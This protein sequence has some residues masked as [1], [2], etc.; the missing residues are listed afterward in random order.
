MTLSGTYRRLLNQCPLLHFQK[1]SEEVKLKDVNP[2]QILQMI[3]GLLRQRRV[4]GGGNA[5]SE[6]PST[7]RIEISFKSILNNR[8][9]PSKQEK[10]PPT[11]SDPGS[12]QQQQHA[13]SK[14]QNVDSLTVS[15]DQRQSLKSNTLYPKIPEPENRRN[16]S[17][18]KKTIDEDKLSKKEQKYN[19]IKKSS[20]DSLG[21]H[22]SKS[23][24]GARERRLLQYQR[25]RSY[26][27]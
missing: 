22:S 2:N 11:N 25:T 9:K 16:S 7:T 18:I 26:N 17:P 5:E 21:T 15:S 24:C 6:I 12:K 3:G 14:K 8:R 19:A 20:S 23:K 10:T 1:A 13:V 4:G 27:A